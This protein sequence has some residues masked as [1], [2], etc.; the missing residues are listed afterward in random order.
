[1]AVKASVTNNNS[2][3]IFP[4]PEYHSRRTIIIQFY[5]FPFKGSEM[6]QE[7]GF[8]GETG[9]PDREYQS[10]SFPFLPFFSY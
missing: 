1:M 5:I 7:V 2:F 10:V 8:K 9:T 6:E 3:R 4:Q